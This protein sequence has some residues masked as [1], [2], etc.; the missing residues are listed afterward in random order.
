MNRQSTIAVWC[1]RLIEA[2]WLLAVALIP[3]YFNLLSSR[4]FEPD[5]A[6]TLRAIVILMS[7]FALIRAIELVGSR[8]ASAPAAA[9]AVSPLRRLIAFPM[10]L[11]TLLYALVFLFATAISLVPYTSFWGSYQRLQGTYTNLSYIGLALLVVFQLRSRAQLERLITVTLL[12]SLV[13]VGYGLL[14][15]NQVDPLP[16]RGD[17][18]S[19]VASTMGNSIFASA[20]LIMVLPLALYRLVISFARARSADQSSPSS[21]SDALW[22]LAYVLIVIGALLLAFAALQFGAVVRTADLRYWWIYLGALLVG[23]SLFVLPTLQIHSR[24]Q[25][26]V[27]ILLPGVFAIVYAL[28]VGLTFLA[29]QSGGQS[30]QPNGRGSENWPI[31]LL[32][33][34]GCIIAAYILFATLP[35]LA[36]A[37]SQ[38]MLRIQGVGAGIIAALLLL[39]I[40]YTQSRGPWIGGLAALFVFV[41]LL[42]N[43]ARARARAA[44]SPRA[45]LWRNLLV[46]EIGLSLLLG[47]FLAVFNTSDAPVFAQ[48]REAPYIGRMGKLLEVDTGTGLV[49][50]LIWTGDDKAGGALALIASDP[51]RAIIGYGPES[52]FVAYNRFYPPALANIESRGASPDR[53]HQAYLDELI[54]KGVLG[55]ASYLFVIFSFFALAWR[56]L[57]RPLPWE[58]Q[59][60]TIGLM[61]VVTAH[62]VE[63]LTGIPVVST[64]MTFWLAIALLVVLGG[65]A[66]EYLLPGERPAAAPASEP[67]PAEMPQ[68]AGGRA[69]GRGAAGRAAAAQQ[70]RA[71]GRTASSRR[72]PQQ[73]SA[74]SLA[75]YGLVVVLAFVAA[76]SFNM[77]N[78]YADMQF[79][80]GQSFTDSPQAGVEQQITGASYYIDAIRME[81]QQDFY[82]LNLGR[83]LMTIVAIEAQGGN[84]GGTVPPDAS[85]E[86]I[87]RL[88]DAAAIQQFVA[89]KSPIELMGYAKATLERARELNPLNKDHYANLARMYNFWY[90]QLSGSKDPALIAQSIDWYAKASA[91]APQDVSILNEYAAA[92]ARSGDYPRAEQLLA[93]SAALDP[94]Y[95]D[96]KTRVAEV[97]RLKGDLSAAV[98]AYVEIIG[99]TPHALDSQ[100]T[101]IAAS[102]SGKPELLTKLRDGYA[103]ALAAKPDDAGLTAIVGLLSDRAGDLPRAAE[104]YA[105]GIALQPGN[106]ELRQNYTLVLSDMGQYAKAADEGQKLLDLVKQQGKTDQK[107]MAALQ[108]LIDFFKA[109]VAGG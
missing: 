63:G 91:I 66:G 31:V 16:W 76:W 3:T 50:R 29:G 77:D 60:L 38:L 30:V 97:S 86:T 105:K 40:F 68:K 94:L 56:M 59:T 12:T 24:P 21:G 43:Q 48:L 39:T 54:N 93:K 52:M 100:I 26:T 17:V 72:A 47:S 95:A 90:Q 92:V 19:R 99:K 81:P 55:L 20:Y 33:A 22:A 87:L 74:G 5:K 34:I 18:V 64:L 58:T 70:G 7:S 82:Y 85:V 15:H 1:E 46:A 102:L 25:L 96:T 108:Q 106:I 109:K 10:A 9:P 107:N 62:L 51:L 45:A 44:G 8:G 65:L 75:L 37:P 104:S 53:S 98:D 101:Q 83:S 49:R 23:A 28:L 6:T 41:T 84:I 13:V 14:Q 42:L 57:R 11:P 61:A 32:V 103:G 71:S 73:T 36:D 89:S 69:S 35:R 78:V 2:G 27:P 80:Q 4:H 67:S 88:P 79:Q